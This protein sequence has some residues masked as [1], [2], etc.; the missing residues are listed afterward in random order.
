M[1]EMEEGDTICYR[2]VETDCIWGGSQAHPPI[3]G[4]SGVLANRRRK[5]DS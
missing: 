5:D 1:E 4:N 3:S 2:R